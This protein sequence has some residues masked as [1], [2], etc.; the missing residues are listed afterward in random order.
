MV[1]AVSNFCLCYAD[2]M[3]ISSIQYWIDDNHTETTV[4]TF[5]EFEVDCSALSAGLHTLHYR[6]ADSYGK[7]SELYEHG[8]YKMP[9]EKKATKI[10][11]LQYWWDDMT[12]NTLSMPYSS[13]EFVLST[14]ALPYGLHNLKYRVKDDAGRWSDSKIH[15]FYKGEPLDSALVVSYSYWWN[16]LTESTITKVLDTPVRE[17]ILDTDLTVSESAKTN[18]AGHYT[19]TLNIAIEDNN[20]R[21]AIMTTNVEY[22]DNE[23]PTTDI[24]ADAYLASSSVKIKWQ[25]TSGD[26]MGDYNVYFSKNGGPFILWLHDTPTNEA[27]FKGEAGSNYI[28][29]VTGRD[30]FGNREV[31]DE[32]KCVSV[33]FE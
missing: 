30:F 8:F 9:L 20:G 13:D 16:N 19:A 21:N 4:T 3:Q 29:T 31:F 28:F 1:A 27:F 15:Y 22:P 6:V 14:E 32:S 11:T 2:A 7:Y 25:E 24:D 18:Y 17:F 10:E 26:K 5:L 33:T 23:A 12:A